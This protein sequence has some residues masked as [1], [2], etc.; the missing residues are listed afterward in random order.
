MTTEP[1]PFVNNQASGWE[2]LAGASP[3]AM[4]VLIDGKASIRRRPGLSNYPGATPAMIDPAGISGLYQV[5]SGELYAVADTAPSRPIYRVTDTAFLNLSGSVGGREL[6]GMGRPVFAE[7]ESVLVVAGGAEQQK[8]VLATH[9][10]SRLGGGPPQS[11]HV[12]A[13]AERLLVNSTIEPNR[14]FYSDLAAGSSF[15]GFENWNG[16]NTSGFFG[17]DAR[18]DKTLA[19]AENTNEVFCFGQGTMQLFGTDP[20]FVFSPITTTEVGVGAPYSIVKHDQ[21]FMWLDNYRRFVVSD[22]RGFSVVSD[23]IQATLQGIANISDCF[24]YRV[25]IGSYDC[26]VWTFPSDGRTFVYQ[27]AAGWGQWSSTDGN[28][29]QRYK[30]NC[31]ALVAGD[32]TNLVG[33][34]DGT[35][36]QLDL[37]SSTDDGAPIEAYIQTGFMN[38]GTDSRKHCTRV[39][40]MLRRGTTSD[41]SA[42]PQAWLMYRDQPGQWEAK[43]PIDLGPLGDAYPVVEFYSL[44]VYQRR[45]WGFEF[46]GPEDLTLVSVVETFDVMDN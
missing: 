6:R 31:H 42:G 3:I 17:V 1:I 12:I 2:E 27:Q 9:E 38:R 7:T 30:V 11:S 16:V 34:T 46:A 36:R 21:S 10:S 32:F 35:V 13:N 43:I 5:S 44:G 22:G 20:T 39:Q 41:P 24:G 28:L 33:T 14:V 4:N 40:V 19:I 23:P 45:Q 26:M 15:A 8:I 37:K 25:I 29:F 18:P